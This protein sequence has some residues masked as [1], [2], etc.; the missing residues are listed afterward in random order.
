[1]TIDAAHPLILTSRTEVLDGVLRM[2]AV[3]GMR[4]IEMRMGSGQ[5][6]FFE[7]C[8]IRGGSTIS[9]GLATHNVDLVVKLG[10]G[11]ESIWWASCGLV[12]LGGGTTGGYFDHMIREVE[13]PTFT[14]GDVLG[15]LV[16]CS[17][18]PT[19]VFFKNGTQVRAIVFGLEMF[20]KVFFPCFHL[21]LDSEIEICQRP[22]L[23]ADTVWTNW[24]N[25]LCNDTTYNTHYI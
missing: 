16:D 18:P 23:P 9:I 19:L 8:C 7:V 17:G 11:R 20:G 5:K 1:M 4:G 12:R 24:T 25:A 14:T 21:F 15:L 10:Y 13:T 22:D 6:G 3:L 2:V